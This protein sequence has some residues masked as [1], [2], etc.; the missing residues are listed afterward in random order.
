MTR[1]ATQP[2]PAGTNAEMSAIGLLVATGTLLLMLPIAPFLIA[3][4]LV[5]KLRSGD[6]TPGQ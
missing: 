4:W 6:E 1:S 3:L 2:N 5:D